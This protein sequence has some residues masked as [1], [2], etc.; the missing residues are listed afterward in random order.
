M[1]NSNPPNPNP[2]QNPSPDPVES[3]ITGPARVLLVDDEPGIRTAVQAYFEDEGFAV[4]TASDGEEGW[5]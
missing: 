4:S 3:L 1:Q 2:N 5:Q